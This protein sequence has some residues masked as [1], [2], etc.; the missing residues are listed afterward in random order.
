M[1]VSFHHIRSAGRS[2]SVEQE[3][4]GHIVA[5]RH[6]RCRVARRGVRLTIVCG[7]HLVTLDGHRRI[8]RGDGLVTVRHVEGHR[9]EVGVRVGELTR[10]K[11]HVRRTDIGTFRGNH[12]V[13]HGGTGSRREGKVVIHIVEVGSGRSRVTR[14]GLLGAVIA[15]GAVRTHDGHRRIDR[16]DGLVTVLNHEGHFGEVGVRILEHRFGKIHEGFAGNVVTFNHIRSA[17]LSRSIE[18]EAGVHIVECRLCRS[19]IARHLVRSAIVRSRIL[20]ALDGHRRGNL[21]HCQ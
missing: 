17:G 19:C 5:G 1:V 18:R 3:A 16:A 4:V 6:S 14:H 8:D 11:A 21:V 20:G 10:C 15:V 2:G 13:H 7:R 9:V 12:I